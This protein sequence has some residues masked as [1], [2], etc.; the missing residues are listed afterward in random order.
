MI[1]SSWYSIVLIDRHLLELQGLICLFSTS[2]THRFSC[3]LDEIYLSSV[4]CSDNMVAAKEYLL[5]IVLVAAAIRRILCTGRYQIYQ[6]KWCESPV[7]VSLVFTN[8]SL[9]GWTENYIIEYLKICNF[10]LLCAVMQFNW[11]VTLNSIH[12]NE[13]QFIR[14]MIFS[15]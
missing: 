6:T 1:N 15:K 9:Q 14:Q 4:Q 2:D 12:K 11:P 10:E 7:L 5:R 13:Q 8:F 3:C